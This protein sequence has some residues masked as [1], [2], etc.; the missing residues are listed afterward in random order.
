M[1]ELEKQKNGE[2]FCNSDPEDTAVKFRARSLCYELSR[3]D[4]DDTETFQRVVKE[5]FGSCGNNL[6][7]KPPY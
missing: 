6:Y 7:L 1:T 5:L 3:T 2:E 4:V